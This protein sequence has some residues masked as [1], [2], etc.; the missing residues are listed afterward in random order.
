MPSLCY[1]RSHFYRC[2]YS[3]DA[4]IDDLEA[5]IKKLGLR[6]FHIYGQSY[7]GILAFEY[8]KR[9]AEQKGKDDGS[10]SDDPEGCL[11]VIFS[12]TPT[13]VELVEAS[14]EGLLDKLKEEDDDE[15]TLGERF[16]LAHQCRLEPMPQP[17]VEAYAHAGTVWRGTAAIPNYVAKPPAEGASRMPSAMIMRGEHDFVDHACVEGWKNCFNHKFVREK[18]VEGCAHHG[19]L[20][21]GRIYGQLVNDFFSEY[22]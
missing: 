13:S 18:V 19:L 15:E 8:L 5:V 22:D 17:L 7:G 12:S 14:A 9:M 4:A 10:T 20:E 1:S 16:R 21:N 3:I 2:R 6:R 11:S